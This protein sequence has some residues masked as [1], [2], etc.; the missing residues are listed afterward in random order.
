MRL[1]EVIQL[2]EY[3]QQATLNKWGERIAQ[4][5]TFNETHLE[6]E[7]FYR[8][9]EINDEAS[10]AKAVL[11]TLESMDPTKNKQYV[12]T[13]VRWYTAVVNT[14]DKNQK[15]YAK[16][17]K[18]EL[19]RRGDDWEP[20]D[21]WPEDYTD[22]G[23]GDYVEPSY[24]NDRALQ[25]WDIEDADFDMY[26]MSGK[27]TFKLEDA[28]QIKTALERFDSIKP[29]LQPNERDIGRYKNFYRFEDFVDEAYDENYVPPET[30]NE[31]L[32]RSDVEVLYNGPLGTVTIPKSHEASC[33]LG[34]G[35]K[36]CT[37]GRDSYWYDSYSRKADLIIYNEKPGN[38]KYQFHVTLN[39]LEARDARDRLIPGPKVRE[40]QKHPVI[41]KILKAEEDKIFAIMAQQPWTSD[42]IT[43]DGGD[44]IDLV[45]K[46]IKFNDKHKGG[47]MRYVDEYYTVYALPSILNS[48]VTIP[49]REMVDL[50][51]TYAKQ[52]GKP[53]PEMMDLM[54]QILRKAADSADL[55][56]N[57]E[58][59]SINRLVAQL[60]AMG[61][62]PKLEQFKADMIAKL[63]DS[64]AFES[65]VYKADREFPTY[66]LWNFPKNPTQSGE[67]V[68][69]TQNLED[70]KKLLQGEM[71]NISRVLKVTKNGSY[72]DLPEFGINSQFANA[73]IGETVMINNSMNEMRRLINIMES[74][75]HLDEGPIAKALGTA[76]LAGTL[77]MGSP[78]AQA[79]DLDSIWDKKPVELSQT[80]QD[81]IKKLAVQVVKQYAG[82]NVRGRFKE[83]NLYGTPEN[84]LFKEI[85]SI[86]HSQYKGS[87]RPR[88]QI[89]MLVRDEA[90]SVM[91]KYL[92]DNKPDHPAI[93]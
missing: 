29:Q 27:S 83:I 44:P 93:N 61:S 34:S 12:M 42:A 85:K 70:I 26:N 84:A 76:A 88:S 53:W 37:T 22:L 89:N 20:G 13:L 19:E 87:M 40:F 18:S 48:R 21:I 68:M 31:T 90:V 38:A 28:E 54:I 66:E 82:S 72:I 75:E 45:R 55:S 4:A 59:K 6:D 41:G 46:F 39:G 11:S 16:L 5:A 50:M 92:Q 17:Y 47:V 81:E 51:L 77:A 62:N 3:N 7:W 49:N 10:L 1:F 74:A 64:Q 65:N 58:L 67:R 30:D 79:S 36:W 86:F 23:K 56:S 24:V 9:N 78:D 73:P 15:L 8:G 2:L 71:P 52:R 25:D 35:T 91:M 43:N 69:T 63:K 32:K 57:I 80:Q 60:D 14:H 33:E